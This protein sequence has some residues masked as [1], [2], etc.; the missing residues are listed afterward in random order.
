MARDMHKAT[1]MI[2]KDTWVWV[3]NY[4]AMNGTNVTNLVRE[5]FEN[6]KQGDIPEHYKQQV[7]EKVYEVSANFIEERMIEAIASR[8]KPFVYEFLHE[9]KMDLVTVEADTVYTANTAVTHEDVKRWNSYDDKFKSTN[10]LMDDWSDTDDTDSTDDKSSDG[11]DRF[12][13][14]KAIAEQEKDDRQLEEKEKRS[15]KEKLD[16]NSGDR[17]LNY[18]SNKMWDDG[19]VAGIEKISRASVSRYRNGK[20]NPKDKSFWERWNVHPTARLYWA[21]L[22]K[23][24]P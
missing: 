24:S 5:F 22:E 4:A 9:Q 1:M 17:K 7:E 11:T 14:E 2:D 12:E 23:I 19:E 18:A 13:A 21:K 6:L 3:Q 16:K 10:S 15:P 20:R 8:V